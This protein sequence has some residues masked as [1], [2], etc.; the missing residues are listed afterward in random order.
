MSAETVIVMGCGEEGAVVEL[1][2]SRG[3]MSK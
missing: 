3:R 2:D 1:Q